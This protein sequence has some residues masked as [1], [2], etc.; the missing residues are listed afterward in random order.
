[1]ALSIVPAAGNIF[2]C[3]TQ[4]LELHLQVAAAAADRKVQTQQEAFS[5]REPAVF[6]LRQKPARF[7]AGKQHYFPIPFISR[8]LR[9]IM[10]A[11]QRMIQPTGSA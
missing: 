10:P 6:A 4:E 8:Y 1:M 5:E 9:K 7:F 3:R 2:H 11:R